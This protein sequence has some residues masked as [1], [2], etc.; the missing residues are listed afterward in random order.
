MTSKINIDFLNDRVELNN[1]VRQTRHTKFLK[2]IQHKTDY[3][4][5]EPIN[6]AIITFNKNSMYFN[7]NIT[8]PTFKTRILDNIT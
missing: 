4:K 8:K 1:D 2:E 7:N 3:G 6:K 5:N